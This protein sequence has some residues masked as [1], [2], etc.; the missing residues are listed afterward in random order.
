MTDAP[1]SLRDMFQKIQS[2]K[3][4]EKEKIILAFHDYK[5]FFSN[6]DRKKKLGVPKMVSRGVWGHY[7]SLSRTALI[8]NT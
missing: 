5:H 4:C 6:F 2:K 3:K 1:A 8:F 7:I